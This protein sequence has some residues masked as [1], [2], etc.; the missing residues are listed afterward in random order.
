MI[1]TLEGTLTAVSTTFAIVDVGGVGLRAFIPASTAAQLPSTGQRV[2]LYTHLYVRE[3]ALNLYGFA[4]A[5]E[6][7]L[8]E[9]L[10]GASGLGPV[11]ALGMLS[12]SSVDG[13]RA[14]IWEE[15]GAVL[16]KLPGIGPRTAARLILDLKSKLGPPPAPSAGPGASTSA[17]AELL[18]WLTTLG[19]SVVQ[20]QA[21]LSKVP[22]EPGMTFEEKAR[23]AL[24]LLRPE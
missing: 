23:T 14:A 20:A 19:F 22:R 6:L 13:I 11:K 3:E 2:R 17:D 8:F 18:S 7:E 1:V 24:E 4:T 21:A 5:G 15:N 12:S 16:A 10:L 9:Q